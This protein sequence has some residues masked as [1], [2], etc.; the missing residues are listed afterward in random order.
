MQYKVFGCKVNKYYT[1]KWLNSEYLSDK[2]GTFVAS[3][4]V[5]DSAKRKWVRFVKKEVEILDSEQK[6]YISWCGAFKDWKAQDDF[7]D[8]YP[9]LAGFQEKIEVLDEAP[10]ENSAE[11]SLRAEE[12][13]RDESSKSTTKIDLSKL[14]KLQNSSIYTRKYLLI[15]WGCDSYCTFCLTVQKRGRH[16]YRSS[17]DIIDE[18]LEYE[19]EWG[20]E[21][22]LTWV[23]L[24]AWGLQNTHETKNFSQSLEKNGQK[25]QG[26]QF[27]KLLEAILENTSIPRIRISSLG[28]EFVDD[29]VLKI[30]GNTR[31]YPHFHFS[32]QS[33]STDVLRSM[34]RHYDWAYM[35]DLLQKTQDIKRDD[36][37]SIS[38]WADLIVW[39]PWETEEDFTDTYKLVKDFNITKVHAFPFSAHTM[40]ESVPAGK[41]KNQVSDEIKK[42]RMQE[43]MTLADTVR[44][45]FL[46]SEKW[47]RFQVLVEKVRGDTFSGWTENYIEANETNFRLESGTLQRNNIIQW[48]LI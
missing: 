25:W 19:Q 17:E 33:G 20:K 37:V 39:F 15:Q 29:A 45:D 9:S 36:G 16:Y 24:S 43:L 8:L 6:V 18:I 3:C 47:K 5:T 7:F 2:S 38:I 46:A 13:K 23:N 48:I 11:V 40:W 10:Q 42:Q 26:S 1:D 41:F 21:V 12:I 34:A 32:I 14:K 27:A 35:R 4:V 28:P 30:L 22:V 31:I 44:S